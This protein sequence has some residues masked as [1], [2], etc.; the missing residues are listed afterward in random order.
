MH[1][2]GQPLDGNDVLSGGAFGGID[3][4]NNRLTFDQDGAGAALGLLAPDL[5]PRETKAQTEEG[6]ERFAR[7]GFKR[8]LDAVDGKEICFVIGVTSIL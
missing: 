2:L 1:P 4:G 6:R 5:G 3:A 7:L 8:L